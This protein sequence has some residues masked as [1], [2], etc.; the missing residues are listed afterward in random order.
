MDFADI[1]LVVGLVWVAFWGTMAWIAY[2]AD[3][4]RKK[5]A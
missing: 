2:R 3:Q 5:G 1:L 4:K